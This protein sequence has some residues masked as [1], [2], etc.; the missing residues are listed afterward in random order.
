[1]C[2]ISGKEAVVNDSPIHDNLAESASLKGRGRFEGMLNVV[3]FNWP[4]YVVGTAVAATALLSAVLVAMPQWCR[5]S[6]ICGAMLAVY[7]LLAS[8]LVSHW[9]YDRSPLYRFDWATQWTPHPARI[10]NIHSGFD[11][12]SIALRAAFPEAQLKILELHDP[13][14]MTEPSIARARRYQERI[15]PPWLGQMTR[16]ATPQALPLGDASIDAVFA[17]LAFHEVRIAD[18]RRKL[19]AEIHRILRG[20]GRLI[21]LEHLRDTANFLVFGP[22]FVHFYSRGVWLNLARDAQLTLIHEGRITPFVGLFVF[23][24]SG[25]N[26][27]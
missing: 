23:E 25:A 10:V 9:V 16:R 17:I 27:S 2:R 14:R 18:E 3:R 22:Q 19:F 15:A 4:L 26:H 11:E 13:A 20:G 7:L 8:L 6:L 12:S 24:K 5:L 21:L 1:M